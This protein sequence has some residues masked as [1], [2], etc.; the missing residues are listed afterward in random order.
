MAAVGGCCSAAAHL[1]RWELRALCGLIHCGRGRMLRPT[2]RAAA[3]D[4]AVL[5]SAAPIAA[6]GECWPAAV[7]VA[8]VVGPDP[9]SREVNSLVRFSISA[10]QGPAAAISIGKASRAQAPTRKVVVFM[11]LSPGKIGNPRR[12]R[13]Y[14]I[15]VN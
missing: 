15:S 6:V 2:R 7:P 8:P 14:A 13:M 12:A 3:D 9:A 4:A 11:T 10:E 5:V 1:P